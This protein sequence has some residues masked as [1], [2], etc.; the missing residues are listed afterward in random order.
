MSVATQEATPAAARPAKK[1]SKPGLE[2]RPGL[3]RWLP[4]L[5][6]A[7]AVLAEL[8]I[9]IIPMIVGIWMSFVKLTK[10]FIA[11]WSAAPAAGLGNYK[12]ALDFD[13]AVGEGLLKSFGVTVVF[14]LVTVAL[15]WVLGMAAAVALQPPFK[16]RA[17][18]RTLFL[19]PYALPAYAGILTWNFMLQRDTGAVNH[20]LEQL[21]LSD[22][23]TFWLIGGNALVSL[24]AVATWKLWTF[25]FLTLMA[26]LQSIPGDLY[27]AASVDGA[28]NL[29]QWRNITLPSLRPVNLVLVLVLFLWTFSD[30]NTPY[31]LFGT[32]QP[33]AGDLI[34]FHIYNA[35]FLTWN[36][37]TG[38]AMSVLLL[39][40]LMIVT[41]IYLLVT[42]R[43]SRRA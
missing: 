14:S 32:A 34:T 41:G 36:F 37:G 19:V 17:M 2:R 11:N 35:S 30:F 39:I 38:A 12:I 16:G 6:L 22:G 8:L 7:P 31:V 20:V 1:K 27:E 9:H 33:P 40:F 42:G 21:H 15:S 4:Y 43:R 23:T 3:N 24:I 18:L 25:A 5:L 29:R 10:F 13:N 28:G 26:G